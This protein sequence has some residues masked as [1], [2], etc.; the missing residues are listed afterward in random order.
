MTC[1][2][3]TDSKILSFSKSIVHGD[4]GPVSVTTNF[5]NFIDMGEGFSFPME[6]VTIVGTQKMAV[7]IGAVY[8]NPD[9]DQSIFNLD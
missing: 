4:E 8:I 5:N 7:R 6:V 9:I 1:Y 3:D 2:F